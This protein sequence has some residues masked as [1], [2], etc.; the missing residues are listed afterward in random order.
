MIKKDLFTQNNIIWVLVIFIGL[1]ILFN[2]GILNIPGSKTSIQDDN[3]KQNT[4]IIDSLKQVITKLE[5][6][7]IKYDSLIIDLKDSLLVLDSQLNKNELKIKELRKKYNE[8]INNI[9]DY[10]SEQLREFLTNRY[11]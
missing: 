7:Q 6:N 2:I 3:I 9:S 8:K 11:K 4:A 5:S 1:L 10:S